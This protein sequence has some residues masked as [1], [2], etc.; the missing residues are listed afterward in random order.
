MIL[1]L[2]ISFFGRL[3]DLEETLKTSHAD[4]ALMGVQPTYPSEKYGYIVP[5][6]QESINGVIKVSHF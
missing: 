2:K 3:L 4:L 1:M 6:I 5:N